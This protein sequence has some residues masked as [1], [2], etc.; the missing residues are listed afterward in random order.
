MR[1]K[2]SGNI[3]PPLALLPASALVALIAVLAWQIHS[4]NSARWLDHTLLMLAVVALLIITGATYFT[5]SLL[6]SRERYRLLAERY[7]ES[8]HAQQESEFLYR[9]LFDSIDDAFCIIEMIYDEHGAPFDYRFVETNPSF[10]TH[11]GLADVRGRTIRDLVPGQEQR[12]FEIYARVT[13]TGKAIRF[14][15][16]AERLGRWFDV[17]AM[18]LGEP[19]KR[20]VAIL[21]RDV[22]ERKKSDDAL[23]EI[24]ER[25]RAIY[26][27]APVGIAQVALDG[28]LLMIN[29]TLCRMLG[30]T[31]SE[32]RSKT[33][34]QITHPADRER[35]ALLLETMLSDAQDSYTLEKR[36]LHR[37][38]DPVWVNI[39][40]TVVRSRRGEPEYRITVVEDITTRRRAEQ[41]LI[42]SEKL[43]VAGR[44]SAVMA[45]EINNPLG[46]VL[47]LLYLISLDHGLSEA[48]A[49]Y[50]DLAQRELERVAYIARQTLGFYRETG[51]PTKVD[52]CSVADDVV[53]LYGPKLT[54][55]DIRVERRYQIEAPIYGIEGELRQVFSNLFSNSI[56]AVGPHGCIRLHIAGPSHYDRLRPRARLTVSDNGKGIP[57]DNLK[58]IFEPFFTTKESTGT[59]LGLWVT[60]QIVRKHGGSIRVRSRLG[61]GTVVQVWL[62][63][64]R[65]SLDR[66]V[67]KEKSEN[68]TAA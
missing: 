6:H 13:E 12:W 9:T 21:F 41:A 59:G 55:K 3:P 46:V 4:L 27:R 68:A 7:A 37:S 5:L 53:K 24:G 29:E 58:Q 66:I 10:E 56:D 8:K 48:N 40:S 50:L 17:Y 63:V 34:E 54:N 36:Y 65:R 47:N 30:Y 61:L 51:N 42:N 45:H 52:L 49:E 2:P 32:M 33:F 23:R 26:E 19:E 35:E 39:V 16:Y 31:E 22:T 20:Q 67:L 14:Q 57:A 38:G 15:E 62:P 44:M 11:T 43:A 28:R 1:W 60:Q 18:P 25:F 64:E